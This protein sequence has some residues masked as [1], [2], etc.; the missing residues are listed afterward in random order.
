MKKLLLALPLFAGAAW[1]GTTAYSGAQTEPAYKLLLEQ[2]DS[3]LFSVTPKD[4]DGGFMNSEAVTEVRS[5]EEPTEEPL[6]L[7]NHKINHSPVSMIPET[8]RF[9]AANIITTRDIDSVKDEELKQILQAFD[10]GEPFVVNTDISIDG[11]SNS[12]IT[13]NAID[14]A[15][16]D[17]NI[18][19]D[20]SVYEI[21]TTMD[22]HI[23]GKGNLNNIQLLDIKNGGEVSFKGAS[24]NF[25]INRIDAS[26]TMQ[27]L[28]G[29]AKIEFNM[30]EMNIVE[31]GQPLANLTGARLEMV[32]QLTEADP[33][34]K[35][36]IGAKK[37]ESAELPLQSF[38]FNTA[39]SGF[40]VEK[41]RSHTAFLVR[42]QEAA[43]PTQILM[44]PEGIDMLRSTFTP[45]TKL[46]MDVKA[47]STE[48][49]TDG[50]LN[51]WFT[52]NGTADGYT[53][54]KTVGD[55]AKAIAG[56]ANIEMDR[57]LLALSPM[58]EMLD[59][60]I[61]QAYLTITD[62]SVILNADLDKLILKLNDQMLPLE[63]MGGEML[64]M[65]LEFLTQM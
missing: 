61:A 19:A 32:Q 22:G 24:L 35:F 3:E 51:I 30:D 60:P 34:F 17:G 41:I 59:D 36:G 4:F 49:N 28:F 44:S 50:K 43:D 48:G 20:K 8:A 23:T 25:D 53:G 54:M 42:L 14:H 5:K 58:G 7:L 47:D 1:A 15:H 10:T 12:K 21:N 11:D 63:L 37:V 27:S 6:F 2:M 39:L 52:G 46:A 56:T 40:S 9:G 64:Q 29:D 13:F 31:R 18:K 33:E 26:T 45:G 65:P 55:L 62:D 16:P 38:D 57:S